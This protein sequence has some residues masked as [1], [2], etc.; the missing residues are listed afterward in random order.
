MSLLLD[1][2]HPSAWAYPLGRV[3]DEAEM[4]SD[5]LGQQ[6]GTQAILYQMAVSTVP[7]EQIKP[8]WTKQVAERFN[9]LVTGLI[10]VR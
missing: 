10:G 8:D 3:F 4:V 7:N 9:K 6:F 1:H 5:R 2:G